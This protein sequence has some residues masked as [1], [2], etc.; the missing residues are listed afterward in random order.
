VRAGEKEVREPDS[1]EYYAKI[2]GLLKEFAN[3]TEEENIKLSSLS[4][5]PGTGRDAISDFQVMLVDIGLIGEASNVQHYIEHIERTAHG[6][7]AMR[8]AIPANLAGTNETPVHILF[9]CKLTE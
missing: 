1:T 7:S 6:C 3:V 9:D 4:P 2:S 5:R 8:D